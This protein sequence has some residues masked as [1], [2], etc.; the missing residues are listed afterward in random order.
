MSPKKD[1]DQDVGGR[2][3]RQ[4]IS[5]GLSVRA[6]A[7]NAGITAGALSQIENGKS[8]PTVTTLKKVLAAMGLTLGEFFGQEDESRGV[9]RFVFRSPSLINVAPG[10]GLRYLSIPGA[11]KGRALQVLH[12]TYA[13]G[14]GTGK[15][16]YHHAGEEAGFCLSGSVEI[17]VDGRREVLGPGDAYYYSSMLP[18]RWRNIGR[19][20]AVVVSAC[21]PPTF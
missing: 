16:H 9:G 14:A 7:A 11:T 3:R 5:R 12:E 6:L 17:T 10:G 20:P 21:T 8:S 4:R 13:P 19:I 15:E 18:H 2:M 1:E